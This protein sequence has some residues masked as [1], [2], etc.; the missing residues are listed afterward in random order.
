MYDVVRTAVKFDI[1]SLSMFREIF[2]I[3]SFILIGLFIEHRRKELSRNTPKE[4]GRVFFAI[5]I[6]L[7]VVGLAVIF[8]PADFSGREPMTM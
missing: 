4:I 8:Q 6:S 2:V 3:L 7:L 1:P 5:V